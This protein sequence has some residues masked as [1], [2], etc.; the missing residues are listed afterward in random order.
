MFE[1]VSPLNLYALFGLLGLLNH[2]W[3]VGLIKQ[4]RMTTKRTEAR[5]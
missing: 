5:P 1:L 2:R 3:T 4:D